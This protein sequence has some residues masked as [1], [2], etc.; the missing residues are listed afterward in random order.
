[1]LPVFSLRDFA[2]GV[3]DRRVS[4]VFDFRLYVGVLDC[5]AVLGFWGWGDV[6]DGKDKN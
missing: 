4:G 2:S 3:F 5:L 6:L 1:V